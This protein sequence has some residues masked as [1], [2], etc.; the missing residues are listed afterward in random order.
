M[1]D[2]S[3][4]TERLEKSYH[5]LT[6]LHEYSPLLFQIPTLGRTATAGV[7]GRFF[8]SP[9]FVQASKEFCAVSTRSSLVGEKTGVE[10]QA[11]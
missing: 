11:S 2:S 1:L 3:V 7:G 4:A 8:K 6:T 9:C 10:E 5:D